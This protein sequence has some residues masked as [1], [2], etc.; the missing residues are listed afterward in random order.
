M[1]SRP[2]TPIKALC[3]QPVLCVAVGEINTDRRR[4]SL[5]RAVQPE[6]ILLLD[7]EPVSIGGLK[8]Q[9]DRG[10][11]TETWEKEL[12]VDPTAFE[13]VEIRTGPTEAPFGWKRIR[14]SDDLPWP[15]P[16]RR[17]VLVCESPEARWDGIRVELTY[18][19][20]D[21]IPLI[22]KWLRLINDSGKSVTV[23]SFELE[24]L[25]I[26][27]HNSSV[28]PAAMRP[29]QSLH[30]QSDLAF[31]GMDTLSSDVTTEWRIEP[32][33]LTQVNYAR[34]TPCLLVSRPPVGPG[35]AVAAGETFDSYRNFILVQD[36]SDRE[37]RGL[38]VRRMHRTLAPWITENPLMMHV[39]HSDPEAVRLGIEQ[40]AEVGFEML[41]LTF[42]SGFNFED[43]SE[44]NLARWRGLAAEAQARGVE[45]GGYSLLSSRRIGP[46]T[47]VIDRETGKPGGA[48]FGNAPCLES[49][50]GQNYFEALR[51]LIE[52]CDFRLLE[53]D[54][55]YPGDTCASTTHPGHRGYEDSQWR[56]WEKIRDF[57]RWCRERGVSLN[58]P[59]YYYLNGSNKCGMGYRET[60]WSL[61]R[62]QQLIHA[63]QNIYD[64]TWEKT[65]SMGWMFVPLTE[66][67]GGGAAATLEPLSEHLDDYAA[68]FAVNL[69]S[70]VQACWRGPRLYD[71][72]ETKELVRSWVDFYKRYRTILESDVIHLRRADGR[73]WDG[74]LHVN[75][76]EELCALASLFN[77]TDETVERMIDLPLYYAGAT[78]RVEIRVGE[79]GAW[80]SVTLDREFG[81]RVT[82]EI[83]AG[84]W[85]PVFVR[86]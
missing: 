58:V 79:T 82:I 83:P 39:R 73:D 61:P 55:N 45:L 72:E 23:D 46:E 40:C 5:L 14:P 3:G 28:E 51:T 22:G 37:R 21:G 19:I 13:L 54:G 53:H 63:R 48:R 9:T 65:P 27:E 67:H 33:Y 70:G 69:G 62:A 24:R 41:I 60:N 1:W 20:Y 16:G 59:D 66:Y 8:G 77:P 31:G 50:W 29:P 4:H 80:R 84:G 57:Y 71:T 15:P 17:V 2:A 81:A 56:Q 36:S 35:I 6:A 26:V 10:Y 11:L 38:A 52:A 18:E 49:E 75:P 7:G 68:H 42:G 34:K 78:D 30:V 76:A 85:L 32:E 44:E 74:L 86:R 47:D 25:S 12:S 64:G 43:V